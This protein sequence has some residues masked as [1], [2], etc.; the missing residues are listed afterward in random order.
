MFIQQISDVDCKLNRATRGGNGSNSGRVSDL[1]Y[2]TNI[3]LL[4][5]FYLK[6][7]TP[8]INMFIQQIFDVDCKLNRATRGENGSNSDRVSDLI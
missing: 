8:H 3:S 2:I 6:L 1:I 5:T 7:K 4:Y